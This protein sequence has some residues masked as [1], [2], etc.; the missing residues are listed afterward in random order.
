MLE[1]VAST[2]HGGMGIGVAEAIPGVV[3]TQD[4][5]FCQV[6]LGTGTK[7]GAVF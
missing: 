3:A 5:A 2:D 7:R 6:E 4:P 1:L